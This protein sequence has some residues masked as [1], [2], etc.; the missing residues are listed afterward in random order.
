MSSTYSLPNNIKEGSDEG[1][2]Y[3][4]G[5]SLFKVDEIEAYVVTICQ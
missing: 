5:S 3:L 2:R 4:A 1:M